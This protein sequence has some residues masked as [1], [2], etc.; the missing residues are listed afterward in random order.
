MPKQVGSYV[1][2][3]MSEAQGIAQS[4][5]TRTK[6]GKKQG[7]PAQSDVTPGPALAAA[8]C[9]AP[10][11]ANAEGFKVRTG[12]NNYRL[13][14]DNNKRL[15]KRSL[16]ENG[17]GRSIVVDNTGASIGGSGVLEQ[18]EELGLPQRI[19]ETD[20]TELIVVVRKD[21]APDDPRRKQLALAD[22]ATTDQSQWDF[23]TLAANF[24]PEELKGWE[25]PV[26]GIDEA[27]IEMPALDDGEKS[28]FEQM[29]FT[30]STAQAETV[31]N[32]I[33]KARGLPDYEQL[34]ESEEAMGGNTNSN[35]NALALIVAG[36]L[37]GAC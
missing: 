36:W 12:P 3:Y 10:A 33:A 1:K 31:R 15:I 26:V 16:A 9:P 25:V 29:T 20:G 37:N 18:A 28:P 34:V 19:V 21:I 2:S 30:L 4:A 17:A 11:T 8:V 24:T 32:A 14:P 7:N 13:H 27:A 35:G 5:P 23:E 22:N 6:A